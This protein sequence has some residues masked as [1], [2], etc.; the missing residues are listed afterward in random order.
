MNGIKVKSLN[1]LGTILNYVEK[2][3]GIDDYVLLAPDDVE[4]VINHGGICLEKERIDART[5]KTKPPEIDLRDR[6]I[7]WYDDMIS[8]GGTMLKAIE[9]CDALSPRSHVIT[10]THPLML[11]ESLSLFDKAQ[12]IVGTDTIPF[13]ERFAEEQKVHEVS[14]ANLIAEE[15]TK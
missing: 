8:T 9:V 2:D 10:T 15:I 4:S 11:P 5:V 6:N 1:A 13:R 14:V 7:V 12:Y 3:L